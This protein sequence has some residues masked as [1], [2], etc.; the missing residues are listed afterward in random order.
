M[1]KQRMEKVDP[2]TTPRSPRAADSPFIEPL[3][4]FP[5]L[6]GKPSPPV[7]GSGTNSTA[8]SA[9]IT[10]STRNTSVPAAAS[11]ARCSSA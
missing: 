11:I 5:P 8:P 7:S 2:A 4:A 6:I 10:A 9:S 1:R 3:P